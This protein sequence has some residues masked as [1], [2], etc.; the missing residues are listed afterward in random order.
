MR[1]RLRLGLAQ[2]G[3]VV[4]RRESPELASAID[5]AVRRGE[6]I[7]LLPGTYALE[8]TPLTLMRSAVAWDPDVVIRAESAAAMWWWPELNPTTLHASTTRRYRRSVQGLELQ[9]APVDPD[10]VG[11]FDGLR[12]AHPALA[13]LDMI[14]RLGGT[15]IDEGLRRRATTLRALWWALAL[16]PARPDNSLRRRLLKESRDEPWSPLE[17]AAH[18]ALRAANIRGW[19]ANHWI[20]LPGGR[21]VCVDLAWPR[22]RIVVELDGWRYHGGRVSFVAD[23]QRDVDLTLDGW[24]VLRYTEESLSDLVPTVRQALRMRA[25]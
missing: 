25:A 15:A 7:K 16:T 18:V 2:G 4:S 6:L 24:T 23:R 11:V 19:R 5:T 14:P 22:Q 9:T 3:G 8:S 1:T 12:L 13:V 21:K 20:A 17:R 10:L